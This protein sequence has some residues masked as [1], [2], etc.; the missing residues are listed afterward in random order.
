MI[1]LPFRVKKISNFPSKAQPLFGGYKFGDK[2]FSTNYKSSLNSL[3]TD[4]PSVGSNNVFAF[5]MRVYSTAYSQDEFSMDAIRVHDAVLKL[6][7]VV[8]KMIPIGFHL[9]FDSV[10][11]SIKSTFYF[12][13]YNKLEEKITFPDAIPREINDLVV[14]KIKERVCSRFSFSLKKPLD[15]KNVQESEISQFETQSNSVDSN[16]LSAAV[17]DLVN[18]LGDQEYRKAINRATRGLPLRKAQILTNKLNSL[19]EC[20]G[21][22][23]I[24]H[25]KAA[26]NE[27][28]PTNIKPQYVNKRASDDLMVQLGLS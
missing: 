24:A 26:S 4:Y 1:S 15:N 2:Y 27:K 6:V 10:T 7:G 8:F 17:F 22:I 16:E 11:R 28:K 21:D 23:S 5:K 12:L 14:R 25:L 20:N 19:I 13:N 3:I 18:L 9:Y